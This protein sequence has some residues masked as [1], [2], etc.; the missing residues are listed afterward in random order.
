M[1][2]RMHMRT[3]K[4]THG[5][6]TRLGP[7]PLASTP[8]CSSITAYRH[9]P[10]HVGAMRG[11]RT[12]VLLQ[13]VSRDLSHALTPHPPASTPQGGTDESVLPPAIGKFRQTVRG[14]AHVDNQ[15]SL[16]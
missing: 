16:R 7:R 9:L 12:N 5:H 6:W 1:A 15:P 3:H 13:P 8:R 2:A 11:V 14:D 4:H 10:V